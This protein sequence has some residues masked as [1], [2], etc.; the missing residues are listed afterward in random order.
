[1]NIIPLPNSYRNLPGFF[2]VTENITINYSQELKPTADMLCLF[3]EKT[4]GIKP[5]QSQYAMI[6][7]SLDFSLEYEQYQ[8]FVD[9]L[10]IHLAARTNHGAFYGLQ[11]LKQLLTLKDGRHRINCTFIDDRPRFSY[12][13]F[14]LDVARHFFPKNEIFRLIDLIS[15]HKFNVLHLHLTDDQGWRIESELYPRLTEIGSKRNRTSSRKRKTQD[16]P[17]QGFYTKQDLKE[18][19]AYAKSRHIEVI[20]EIDMPGHMNA[21]I[22]AYPQT[23][24][25]KKEIE[26]RGS[27]GIS[28]ITLCPGNMDV[29]QMLT[30]IIIEIIDIFESPYFHL[31][32]DEVPKK[33]WK[34]CPLCQKMIKD[35]NL[36]GENGLA[37]YFLNYFGELLKAHNKIPIIWNDGV[38]SDTAA[39]TVIQHW[40]P[41]TRKKTV[42]EINHGRKAIIS[43]FLYLYLDYPYSMTPLRKTYQFEP[44]DKNIRNKENILGVEAPLWTEW[45]PNQYK[46]DYQI[47]PRLA[48]V[49]EIAWTEKYNKSYEHFINRL[50]SFYDYYRRMRVNYAQ[51]KE[52]PPNIIK[53]CFN[54][55][56]WL[57]D[58]N[59]EL[60][61]KK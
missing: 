20:P 58:E 17:H 1:M 54:V 10:S 35:N 51:G 30:E 32:G 36:K 56:L 2:F 22:A 50:D 23:S 8:L 21:L 44:I 27:F 41:F 43:D 47:F 45:V 12:R 39:D 29:Y 28:D 7:L 61:K 34:K 53:R 38:D 6:N 19:V 31:G 55:L 15:F 33:H 42:K 37:T 18:I 40:K 11:T 16:I 25:L 4:T 57:R 60:Q 48:A 24:C 13:G 46:L 9:T 14:M 5:K 3:L 49:A 52:F 59:N 26:V